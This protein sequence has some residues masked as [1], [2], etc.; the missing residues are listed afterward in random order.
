MELDSFQWSV[1]RRK[2]QASDGPTMD[3][4]P[5]REVTGARVARSSR[6]HSF[7]L[8]A[9]PNAFQRCAWRVVLRLGASMRWDDPGPTDT[10]WALSP[11]KTSEHKADAPRGSC[12]DRPPSFKSGEIP[13]KTSEAAMDGL[14]MILA[15][16]AVLLYGN[17]VM[18]QQG[19]LY[20]QYKVAPFQASGDVFCPVAGYGVPFSPWAEYFGGG[21]EGRQCRTAYGGQTM[22][23]HYSRCLDHSKAC[24][25]MIHAKAGEPD[26]ST[27]VR[28]PKFAS[29]Q[30]EES[31]A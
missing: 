30:A 2:H 27:A 28:S 19:Q 10:G 6:D 13:R 23:L 5:C 31:T 15:V 25:T 1:V 26:S 18:A 4:L 29:S 20:V 16:I 14:A 21:C 11:L 17:V 9:A 3:G 8:P 7:Q 24:Q 22:V 12:G